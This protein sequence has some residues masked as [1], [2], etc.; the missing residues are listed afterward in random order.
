MELQQGRFGFA[1]VDNGRRTDGGSQDVWGFIRSVRV[2]SLELRKMIESKIKTT[3]MAL[4]KLCLT[5]N[6]AQVNF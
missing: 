1:D 6:V 2:D 3:L 4:A 5:W